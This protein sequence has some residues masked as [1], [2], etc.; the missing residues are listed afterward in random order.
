M[1]LFFQYVDF[2]KMFNEKIINILF[3]HDFQNLAIDTQNIS[4]SFES[5]YNL[6]EKKFK[7]FKKYLDKHLQN[8]FIIFSK[9]TCA[10]LILFIK[11]KT[12]NL[13]LC[14]N[15]RELNAIIVKNQ[16]FF[17]FINETFD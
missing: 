13:R 5:F 14:V 7:T 1:K 6:S 12:N 9:S 3:K 15:Y 11:K 2:A 4:L 17:S 10:A 16:Y 8:E